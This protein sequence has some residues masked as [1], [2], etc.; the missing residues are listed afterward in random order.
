M[1]SALSE[2]ESIVVADAIISVSKLLLNISRAGSHDTLG[3]MH[4][5]KEK[6]WD[7]PFRPLGIQSV[8][9]AKVRTE[10]NREPSK[11]R[12]PSVIVTISWNAYLCDSISCAN[13]G[14]QILSIT[15]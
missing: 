5:R 9:F 8:V 12:T 11:D 1:R 2:V 6:Q 14:K 13:L 7:I 15:T 10:N 3:P 4:K